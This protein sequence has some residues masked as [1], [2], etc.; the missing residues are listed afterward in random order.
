MPVDNY[1]EGA[2]HDPDAPW[3]DV[4][5]EGPMW[6]ATCERET[7]HV[8]G[9]GVEWE[10]EYIALHAAAQSS[11]EDYVAESI[12][13]A[14]RRKLGWANVGKRERDIAT[15]VAGMAEQHVADVMEAES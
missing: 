9:F 13:E 6:C 3:N 15:E 7:E 1:P 4:P 12:L 2:V 8:L 5:E 11:L 14:F 10:C